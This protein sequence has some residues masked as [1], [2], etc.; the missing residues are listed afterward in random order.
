LYRYAAG[1]LQTV[2]LFALTPPER[3]AFF[4]NV[5]NAMVVHVTAAVGTFD[6]FFDQLTFFGRYKYDIGGHAYSCD[7][8]EHG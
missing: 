3:T 5:Y 1:E 6:G 2:D 4:I 8:I 7:D